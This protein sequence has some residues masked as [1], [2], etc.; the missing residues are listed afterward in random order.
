MSSPIRPKQIRGLLRQVHGIAPGAPDD[1]FVR[2]PEDVEQAALKTSDILNNLLVAMSAIA[3]L[4]GGL[5][6]MNVMLLSVSE[7]VQ[8]IRAPK[9]RRCTPAG[10]RRPV[11]D[12][13][14][15]GHSR[16]RSGGVLVGVVR[17]PFC[18]RTWPNRT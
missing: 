18:C 1:F 10:Y 4:V 7:R 12:G 16:G 11:F 17:H 2:E 14:I 9:G 15:A 8:E 6:I 13:G 5:I 3:F